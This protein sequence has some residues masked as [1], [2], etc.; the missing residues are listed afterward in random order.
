MEPVTP[1]GQVYSSDAFAALAALQAPGQFRFD[2]IGRIPLAKSF[3]EF[4]MYHVREIT[5]A[6]GSTVQSTFLGS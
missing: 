2:Y 5:P 6:G 3:G 4:P 1:P